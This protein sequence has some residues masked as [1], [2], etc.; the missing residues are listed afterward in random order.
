MAAV[1]ENVSPEETLGR[2]R[3][4]YVRMPTLSLTSAQ[5]ARLW[6]LERCACEALLTQLVD[7]GFLRQT[8]EGLYVCARRAASSL[9]TSP[10]Q[11]NE[12]EARQRR[13]AS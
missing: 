11:P 4:T 12:H 13:A 2:I 1:A 9:A 3:G 7:A 8:A 5:A 10:A 6:S